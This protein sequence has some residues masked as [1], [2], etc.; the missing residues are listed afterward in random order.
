[1]QTQQI[2]AALAYID[3]AET[4]RKYESKISVN[5]AS[6]NNIAA[7]ASQESESL[8]ACGLLF[9]VIKIASITEEYIKTTVVIYLSSTAK[10]SSY[11]TQ[12]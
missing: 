4:S 9:Q 3:R 12:I 6:I 11:I 1:V 7:D 10:Y 8:Y 5:M 2:W